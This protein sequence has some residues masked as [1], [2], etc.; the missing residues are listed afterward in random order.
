MPDNWNKLADLLGTPSIDPI[1]RKLSPP[2]NVPKAATTEQ[3]VA[4]RDTT[5]VSDVTPTV[6]TKA[7]VAKSSSPEPK[8]RLKNTWDAVAEFFGVATSEPAT[9]EPAIETAASTSAESH[10][11]RN[12]LWQVEEDDHERT[13]RAAQ[14]VSDELLGKRNNPAEPEDDLEKLLAG[15]R[16]RPEQQAA[17][18]EQSFTSAATP[19]DE[20]PARSSPRGGRDRSERRESRDR[21]ERR[22]PRGESLERGR[23]SNSRSGRAER[24]AEDRTVQTE[25]RGR[26]GE[27]RRS[28]NEAE[29]VGSESN[30]GRRRSSLPD[31]QRDPFAADLPSESAS[32]ERRG[33]R[34]PS[35]RAIAEGI[36]DKAPDDELNVEFVDRDDS[37]EDSTLDPTRRRQQR[38]SRDRTSRNPRRDESESASERSSRERDDL[39]TRHRKTSAWEDP[40]LVPLSE[41]DAELDSVDSADGETLGDSEGRRRRRRRRRPSSKVDIDGADEVATTGRQIYGRHADESEDGEDEVDKLRSA[42]IVPWVDAISVIVDKNM[43][44]HRHA[45]PNTRGG[46]GGNPRGGNRRPPQ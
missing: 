5:T 38:W 10:S 4:P 12:S 9:E 41:K 34:R 16:Q 20:P 39:P 8:S 11:T 22:P 15:F 1:D 17:S 2:K 31:A 32:P 43:K 42:V 6:A 29:E 28:R 27:A 19:I 3:V 33:R 24:D 7:E 23:D 37:T 45:P 44:N 18:D 40:E 36:V 21:S 25:S 35:R 14:K 26:R 30:R 46:R 13:Q